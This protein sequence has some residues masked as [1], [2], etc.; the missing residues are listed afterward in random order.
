MARGQIGRISIDRAREA[1]NCTPIAS[2]FLGRGKIVNPTR[3]HALQL[4]VVSSLRAS[5]VSR[6]VDH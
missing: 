3:L 5:R 2:K 6:R 4:D 1:P